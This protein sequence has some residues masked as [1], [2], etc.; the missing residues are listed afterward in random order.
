VR[1]Y[2]RAVSDSK[3]PT[4]LRTGADAES[5]KSPTPQTGVLLTLGGAGPDSLCEPWKGRIQAAVA[6]GL[7]IQRIY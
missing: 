1:R 2:L 6:A 7:S 5:L 4:N 3:S